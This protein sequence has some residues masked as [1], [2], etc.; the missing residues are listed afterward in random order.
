MITGG[1]MIC[2][3]EHGRLTTAIPMKK[4]AAFSDRIDLTPLLQCLANSLRKLPPGRSTAQCNNEKINRD[5][6]T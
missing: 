1:T 3:V 6:H 2:G 4:Q 5:R